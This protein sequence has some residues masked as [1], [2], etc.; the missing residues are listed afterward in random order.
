MKQKI[1]NG[2][3]ILSFLVLFFEVLLHKKIVFD[4]ISYSINI[5]INTLIPSMFPFFII[6][7]ILI[8]Y[9]ITNYIPKFIKYYFAK[10]FN[11]SEQSISIFFLSL[12][13]GFPSGA[14]NIKILYQKNLIIINKRMFKLIC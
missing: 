4:T 7:D 14:R 8:N 5:W 9:Q 11:V 13:S 6:S 3:I 10:I 1:F 2:L 12:F